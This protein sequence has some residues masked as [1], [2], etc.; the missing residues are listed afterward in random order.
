MSKLLATWELSFPPLHTKTVGSWVL[1]FETAISTQNMAI[2][3][4]HD[5][6]VIVADQQEAGRGCHGRSWHSAPGLG[7]WF[8]VALQGPPQGLTWA[9]ALA[10]RNALR[11]DAYP[12][13]RWPNDLIMD[14]LKIAGVLVEHRD[15]WSA[16]GIGIN[17]HHKTEDFPIE[18]R[19]T[20]GSLEAITETEWDRGALLRDVLEQL[21]RYVLQIREGG[22][23][24]L[25]AEWLAG[26]GVA[27]RRV[28]DG[29][30]TGVA[31]EIDDEG[32]LLVENESGT[33]RLL[34]GPIEYAGED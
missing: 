31:R 22:L 21:D 23:A 9:G 2:E 26:C 27:G 18:L 10:V 29:T 30:L 34:R 8:S 32:A 17:V 24:D 28:T 4:H 12:E 1:Y 19:G 16:L 33:H 11:P 6:L 5:G 13:L 3:H 7:L 20:A 14:G 15:G 25:R